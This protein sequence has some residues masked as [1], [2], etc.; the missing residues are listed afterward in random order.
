MWLC[1]SRM[2]GCCVVVVVVVA[3]HNTSCTSF[4]SCRPVDDRELD[5]GSLFYRVSLFGGQMGRAFVGRGYS[6]CFVPR[7]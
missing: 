6:S 3:V 1:K 7:R 5:V 2:N 4:F